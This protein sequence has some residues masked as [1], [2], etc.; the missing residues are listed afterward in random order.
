MN[1]EP[2]SR[3]INRCFQLWRLAF[4]ILLEVL[5]IQYLIWQFSA[6]VNMRQE[7][8]VLAAPLVSVGMS[9]KS[10]NL[11]HKWALLILKWK[12]LCVTKLFENVP[13]NFIAISLYWNWIEFDGTLSSKNHQMVLVWSKMHVS[14]NRYHSEKPIFNNRFFHFKGSQNG[15]CLFSTLLEHLAMSLIGTK[16]DEVHS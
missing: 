9:W 6:M 2:Y 4:L 7:G 8:L 15:L 13:K 10:D 14:K 1:L 12:T 5:V 3:V 16:K 11:L